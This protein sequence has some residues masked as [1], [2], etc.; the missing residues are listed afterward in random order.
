MRLPPSRTQPT[1]D[2]NQRRGR[3]S[4]RAAIRDT[5]VIRLTAASGPGKREDPYCP[6]GVL[7][8]IHL[9]LT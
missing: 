8:P 4:N 7:R 3:S 1:P 2:L 9:L 5:I 6:L